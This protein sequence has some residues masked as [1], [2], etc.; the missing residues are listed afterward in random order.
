MP[1]LIN[2]K[3]CQHYIEWSHWQFCSFVGKREMD[4]GRRKEHARTKLSSLFNTLPFTTFLL[5]SPT[6]YRK[7]FIRSR[8]TKAQVTTEEAVDGLKTECWN[9][10]NCIKLWKGAVESSHLHLTKSF[11]RCSSSDDSL[12]QAMVEDHEEVNRVENDPSSASTSSMTVLAMMKT[13][14]KRM[15]TRIRKTIIATKAKDTQRR[16]QLWYTRLLL[17]TA[18]ISAL[19]NMK[20]KYRN[21]IKHAASRSHFNFPILVFYMLTNREYLCVLMHHL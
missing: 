11:S 12:N 6:F 15:T 14:M 10:V 9:S 5:I 20:L 2:H 4:R 8:E 18:S 19:S 17:V 16:S 1:Y 13:L 7:L 3:S 21:Q